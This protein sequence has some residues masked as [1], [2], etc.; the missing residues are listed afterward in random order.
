MKT[1]YKG[2]QRTQ[3][4]SL[5]K[6]LNGS[7]RLQFNIYTFAFLFC[8]SQWLS[9]SFRMPSGSHTLGSYTFGSYTFRWHTTLRCASLRTRTEMFAIESKAEP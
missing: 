5:R 4:I 7:K 6:A 9:Y 2:T 8:G 1:N 3:G